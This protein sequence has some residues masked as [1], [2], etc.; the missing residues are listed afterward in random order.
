MKKKGLFV[1]LDPEL[2][3][4]INIYRI[5]HNYKSMQDMIEKILIK[6]MEDKKK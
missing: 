3:K 4:E 6:V 5:K 2:M 1:R